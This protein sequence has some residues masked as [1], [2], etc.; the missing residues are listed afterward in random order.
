MARARVLAARSARRGQGLPATVATHWVRPS[1]M[2]SCSVSTIRVETPASRRRAD[3]GTAEVTR[4]AVPKPAL[5]RPSVR[6]TSSSCDGCFLLS[7]GSGLHTIRRST[8]ETFPHRVSFFSAE[9]VFYGVLPYSTALYHT[10]AA[11]IHI[12]P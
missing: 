5:A 6:N 3:C 1:C 9:Q 10:I 8:S 4:S 11:S 12:A 2:A 7:L